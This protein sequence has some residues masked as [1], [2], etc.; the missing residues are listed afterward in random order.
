MD[1]T[2]TVRRR[3]NDHEFSENNQFKRKFSF[4]FSNGIYG[5]SER[6]ENIQNHKSSHKHNNAPNSSGKR[7]VSGQQNGRAK[8][9]ISN[10]TGER[11]AGAHSSSFPS[12]PPS[13]RESV[14]FLFFHISYLIG[15][16]VGV[17]VTYKLAFIKLNSSLN[18]RLLLLWLVSLQTVIIWRLIGK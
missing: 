5:E 1:G 15:F 18:F 6:V 8:E 14:S 11:T 13:L 16:F 3:A 9:K 7:Y 4:E 10:C 17:F 2:K 12:L